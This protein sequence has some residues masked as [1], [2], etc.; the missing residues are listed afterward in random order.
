MSK[1][2]LAVVK[3]DAILEQLVHDLKEHRERMGGKTP[4]QKRWL[5]ILR[6]E[7][8]EHHKAVVEKDGRPF[9]NRNSL[10]SRSGGNSILSLSEEG[11]DVV[12]CESKDEFHDRSS[13]PAN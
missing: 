7:Q 2:F 5:R 10:Q 12:F 1:R 13:H 11:L 4:S 6:S 3:G 9:V 8:E